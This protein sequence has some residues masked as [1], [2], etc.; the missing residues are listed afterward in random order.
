MLGGFHTSEGGPRPRS[1]SGWLPAVVALLVVAAAACGPDAVRQGSGTTPTSVARTA[2]PQ[3][4]PM[5]GR[6]LANTRATTDD[7][8][9]TRGNVGSLAQAWA[10]PNL[11]GVSSTPL[12]VDR[13]VYFGDW[14]G[15]V[16]ALG[17]DTGQER[18]A[19]DLHTYYIGG[20]PAADGD[21]LF[22][23]TFD[24]R[25][26]ALDRR[27]GQVLWSTPVDDGPGSAVFASPVV[28]DGVVIVGVASFQEFTNA[29]NATFRG[30][31]VG[32]DAATG[33]EVWR[34]WTTDNDATSGPG[35]AVWS[36]L[37]VDAER[38][39]AYVPTGN[40]YL[41]PSGPN[42]DAV[43]AIDTRTGKQVWVTRFTEGDIWTLGGENT[44]PDADVGA[45]PNLFDID[46]RPALGVGD[47]AGVFHTLDRTSGEVLWTTPLTKGGPQG[48]VMASG[49][50]AD[51]R[52]F[53]A[54]NKG[55]T[56]A[57]VIA[58]DS[59]SGREI[60]RVDVGGHSTGPTTVSN[61]IV[62]IGDDTGRYTAFDTA[63]GRKLWS[64]TVPAPAAAGIT[65]AG[66]TIFA[67]FGWWL[68]SAPPDPQGGLIAY[69]LPAGTA[70]GAGSQPANS[71]AADTDS[72]G[73]RT[74]VRSCA[75]CHG[76]NGTG[77]F[78]PS[79]IGVA[80]RLT[81]EQHLSVVQ[82][83]RNSRMP[84]WRDTLTPEEI[85]AVV[86]YERHTFG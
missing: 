52:L 55:G 29:D 17:A 2:V 6:D 25:I 45:P 56:T 49:A 12:Y 42:A 5:H 7:T 54:S 65:V 16:R 21:R 9:I 85:A 63:D 15:H 66:D 3:S 44:G 77:G 30:H 33:R 4:W 61:D 58:L 43:V 13:T 68:A 84:A 71:D 1:S 72:P 47:K 32:V 73:R 40:N 37:S 41:P 80:G 62:F 69:R 10:T 34:Y 20:S 75:S 53:V 24:S 11:R 82:N 76:G 59:R 50:F 19:T 60:W 46:G 38:H 74:Y 81:A 79:L 14:T 64:V 86:D 35:I 36:A 22:V 26:T 67:G 83:G 27:S 23:G 8:T 57:D 28:V 31:V 39:L 48:G 78:G 70:S 51:G 18:W